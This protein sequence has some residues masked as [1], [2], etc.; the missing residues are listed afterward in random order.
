MSQIRWMRPGDEDSIVQ[1][2][3]TQLVPL[4]PRPG[5]RSSHLRRDIEKRLRRGAT[6]VVSGAGQAQPIA[7]LHLEVRQDILF[8][9]LLAVAPSAQN[10]NWGTELM[11]QA[12]VYGVRQGC[13]EAKVFVDDTNERGMRFYAKLGYSVVRHIR[14]AYCYELMKFLPVPWAY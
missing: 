5:M 2:V 8:I 6:L 10:R 11:R 12:E 13:T 4:S 9:D 1:L 14:D 7:F 3:K